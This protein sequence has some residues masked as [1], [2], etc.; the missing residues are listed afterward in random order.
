MKKIWNVFKV[1]LSVGLAITLIFLAFR[2]VDF[3]EFWSHTD[4]VNYTWIII[5]MLLSIVGYV[6]RA[7]RWRLLL[8]PLDYRPTLYRTSISVFIGYLANLALP[9]LG[10]VMRC[11]FLLRTNNIPINKSLGTVISERV[12]DLLM[13]CVLI[14][15][16][17]LL[18]FDLLYGFLKS[19]FQNLNIKFSFDII[20]WALPPLIIAPIVVVYL[21]RKDYLVKVKAFIVG[22]MEGV[23]SVR[24]IQNL[25]GFLLS[26]LLI[27]TI[28]YFMS[29]TIIFS[30]PASQDLGLTA[31]LLLLV[32]GGI[33]ISLPVQAGFGTYHTMISGLL[34]LY[35]INQTSGLFLATLLHTS[36]VVAVIVFGGI[37]LFLALLI[38]PVNEADKVK[39]KY[40]EGDSDSD[41][42]MA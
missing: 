13:L 28:Y 23:S 2:N 14:F 16:A 3:E 15:A 32:T 20:L 27:W 9:R 38:K 10:E 30:L 5:S 36:Q 25:Q 31:G 1:V 11:T 18:E 40:S 19:S 24:K 22:L 41:K 33:A 34:L 42:G 26:T 37:S 21:L 4:Q 17:F 35:G 6:A 29:Y 39:N 8:Q 12:V 7:Y